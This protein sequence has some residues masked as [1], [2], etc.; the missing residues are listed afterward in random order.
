[1]ILINIVLMVI[2]ILLLS[3][4]I[5]FLVE[6][7]TKFELNI[8]NKRISAPM[9]LSFIGALIF[10]MFVIALIKSKMS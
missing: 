8:F 1:M 10:S 6:V 3:S 9:L 2:V 7:F 4:I 5:L